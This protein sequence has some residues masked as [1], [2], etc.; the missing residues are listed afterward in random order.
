[1]IIPKKYIDSL[2]KEHKHLDENMIKKDLALSYILQE[3]S[4]HETNLI[5]KGGTCLS[6]C[7]LN[8]HRLSEDLDFTIDLINKSKKEKRNYFKDE[9]L[10]LLN[11]ICKKYSFDFDC[12]EFERNTTKYCPV[13]QS[14]KLFRFFI[15]INKKETNPI[16]IE[17]NI[18]ELLVTK[19]VKI[20][21][22]NLIKENNNLLFPL[23]EIN[24]LSYTLEEII[25]EKIRA[26]LTREIIQERDIYDLYEINKILKI[27]GIKK[28]Y[29]TFQNQLSIY[30]I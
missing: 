17:I 14:N 20:K 19:P 21:A 2:K 8:Y 11:T 25:Y 28:L 7:Y 23:N 5:F 4:K 29:S 12:E 24:V 15:Y 1:M 16:K 13:K 30:S 9:I 26:L 10:P 27:K 3:L 22:K 18:D 6:K